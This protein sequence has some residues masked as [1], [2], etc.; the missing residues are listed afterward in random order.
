VYLKLLN[1]GQH[2][3]GIAVYTQTGPQGAAQNRGRSLIF[4]IALFVGVSISLKYQTNVTNGKTNKKITE[5]L[6][7]PLTGLCRGSGS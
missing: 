3:F 1:R 7:G 2:G 4:A 6:P 5:G